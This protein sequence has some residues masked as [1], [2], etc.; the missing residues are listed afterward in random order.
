MIKIQILDWKKSST[1]I[2]LVVFLALLVLST[3]FIINSY[4]SFLN[5]SKTTLLQRLQSIS[6][7]ISLQIDPVDIEYFDSLSFAGKTKNEVKIDPKLISVNNKLTKAAIINGIEEPISI[8]F[9]NPRNGKFVFIAN[10]ASDSIFFNDPYHIVSEDFESKYREGG[11][12]G[13]YSDE[14]GTWLTSLTP[15]INNSKSVVGAIEVDLKFDSFISKAN[16]T[17]YKNLLASILIFILTTIIL[18]RYVR[19]IL[20]FEEKIQKSL[21]R[22]HDIIEEKNSEIIQSINYALRI[23]RA[24][25]P[26]E[27]VIVKNLPNSFILYK[28][29]DIVAG[30]FYWLESS[31]D[32]VFI[33]ACDCTGHGVPGAM[34][35]VVCHNALNRAVKEFG[36]IYPSEILDKTGEIVVD[37]FANSNEDI[38][39]GMDISLCSFDYK[40]KTLQWA[41]AN[42]ALWLLKD[43]ELIEIKADK[44]PIGKTENIQPFTNHTFSLN[45][46][47]IVFLF[48]DG[49]ADQFG[50]PNGQKKLTRKKFKELILSISNKSINEQ[51]MFLDEFITNYRKDIEQVDD[52]LVMA[53]KV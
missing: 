18:L 32:L 37:Y 39:D 30:D 16:S 14:F 8:I 34:V 36:K 13:P 45:E 9:H 29:K 23:Q 50:G 42:N 51:K 21:K 6:N 41:G 43:N 46:G 44:Q 26:S 5:N 1:K 40:T 20:V 31:Q 53:F 4:Q 2:L 47:D 38:K 24:I 27:E 49:Y 11:T 35:S 48:T 7:T 33:A 15:I 10:S 52:I 22:S 3:F 19:I 12:L 28:P 25:L 17:L